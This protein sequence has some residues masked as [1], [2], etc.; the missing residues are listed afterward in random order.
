MGSL[1]SAV[2]SYLQARSNHGQWLLRIE[3]IDPPREIPGSALNIIHDLQVFGM[4]SDEPIL[5]QSHR[6]AAYRE[7]LELLLQQGKAFRCKCSRKSLPHSSRYPGHC[8]DLK[9]N[10][11]AVRLKVAAEHIVFT[12]GLQGEQAHNLDQEVGDFIIWRGDDLAAYQLAVVLD[13]HF[14]GITEVV[15]GCDLLDSSPRQICL[16]R[17]LGITS[18]KYMHIPI[19]IDES[20]RKLSKSS[21]DDPINQLIPPMAIRLCLELL[22]QMPAKE[23]VELEQLWSWAITNWE[24]NNIPAQIAPIHTNSQLQA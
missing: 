18:P 21:D 17:A 11:T 6:L 5:Y 2:A 3:D 7:S 13:D 23:I 20:G 8:R 9:T 16:Q 12:D 24:P 1:L 14:Q 22:G 4:C 15:R 10:G 19:I